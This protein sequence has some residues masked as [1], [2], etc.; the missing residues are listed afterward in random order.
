MDNKHTQVFIVA[1]RGYQ[2][3]HHPTNDHSPGY[4]G[5]SAKT[6]NFMNKTNVPNVLRSLVVVRDHHRAGTY[7][8]A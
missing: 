5:D 7:S 2:L 8:Y 6:G 3:P 4:E 1:I